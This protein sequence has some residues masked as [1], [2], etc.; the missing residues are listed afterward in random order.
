MKKPLVLE[1]LPRVEA[2][3]VGLP[4]PTLGR[5]VGDVCEVRAELRRQGA[6]ARVIAEA[7]ER[8]VR[9]R[10]PYEREWKYLC[11]Q[12]DDTGLALSLGVTNR[13]GIVVDVGRACSCPKGNLFRKRE[14]EAADYTQAGKAPAQKKFSRW[15]R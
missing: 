6:S 12:C 4:A 8:L 5:L 2:V 1:D 3:I 11:D 10:W 9:D 13:L 14:P 7:T 15:G